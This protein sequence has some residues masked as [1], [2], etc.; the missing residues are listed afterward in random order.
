MSSVITRGGV[1]TMNV[2]ALGPLQF[3]PL[4]ARAKTAGIGIESQ[5]ARVNSSCGVDGAPGQAR[6]GSVHRIQYDPA[7][8]SQRQLQARLDRASGMTQPRRREKLPVNPAKPASHPAV[9]G[10]Q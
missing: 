6:V 2:A 10:A 8:D 5:R 1:C 3:E 4:R 9:Y 7:R